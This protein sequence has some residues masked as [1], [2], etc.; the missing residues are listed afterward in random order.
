ME[1]WKQ[2]ELDWAAKGMW[3][4]SQPDSDYATVHNS[5]EEIEHLVGSPDKDQAL[6]T[7]GLW[8]YE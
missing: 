5:R 1:N 2:Y 4:G 7:S 8:T 6:P 3:D